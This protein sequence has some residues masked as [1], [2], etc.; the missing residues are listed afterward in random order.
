MNFFSSMTALRA[1]V[2]KDLILFFSN[3]RA[4][5]ITMVMPIVLG[6]FMGYV[7]GG[8][9]KGERGKISIAVVTEDTSEIGKKI[10]AEIKADTLLDVK[11]LPLAEARELVSKGK[12]ALAIEIPAGF[13]E[14][15][16]AALFSGHDKPLMPIF[17]DP[18]QN[19]VLAMVKGILTQHVMQVVSAEMFGGSGGRKFIDSTMQQL[20]QREA[21]D[22]KDGANSELHSFLGSLKKFQQSGAAG[23]TTTAD[24]GAAAGK[25]GLT[26]PYTTMEEEIT[27]GP[28]FNGYGH[29]FGG[30]SVQ[31]I[32]MLGIAFGVDILVARRDGM[33]NRLLA[34]PITLNTILLARALSGAI[35]AFVVYCAIFAVAGVMFH[36][37]VSNPLGFVG[38]GACFSLM[39]ACFGLLI[40]AFGK[41][42]DA[43]RSIAMFV[44]L[45]LVMLGGAWV[46]SFMF[47]AWMQSLTLYV[48]TRWAI[49]GIA[50]M[51]WRGLGMDVALQTMG[52]LLAFTAAFGALA[53][54]KFGRDGLQNG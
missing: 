48:P 33:W 22:G 34:A 44:T 12:L 3:R 38:I 19:T 26:M 35:I 15:A 9:G 17:F 1:L 53:F 11:E 10:A 30:M 45:I 5:L 39:V 37:P 47:P 2:R 42:P 40:A 27:S 49:D 18:S 31:F 16:G 54:W 14:A 23:S 28:K 52:V 21:K 13:G 6:A 24:G 51:T 50:A 32:L 29:S 46:P 36:V 20:E 7:F 41:T 4:L 25:G 43:A 8:S